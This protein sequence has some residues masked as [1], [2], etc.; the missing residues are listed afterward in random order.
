[1]AA[2]VFLTVQRVSGEQH[3]PHPEFLDQG[4]DGGDLVA[5]G[6]LLVG[7]DERRFAAEST[8]HLGSGLVIQVIEAAPEGFAVERDD[9]PAGR[10]GRTAQLGGMVAEGGLK[11]GRIEG[12]EQGAQRV[13]RRRGPEAGAEGG[14]EPLAMHADEQAD[15]AVGGGAGQHGQDAE[16]QQVW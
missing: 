8:Q 12:L 7:E 13:D 1:V 11:L 9:A 2:K 3:T 16:Q 5:L 15:T 4:L 10:R 14:V 6:D